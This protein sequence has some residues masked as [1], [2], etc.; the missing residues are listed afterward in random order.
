MK[1]P[2]VIIHAIKD[3]Y[4]FEPRTKAAGQWFQSHVRPDAAR[5]GDSLV[6]MQQEAW[7][8]IWCMKEAGLFLFEPGAECV[9]EV[10]GYADGQHDI[11]CGLEAMEKGIPPKETDADFLRACGIKPEEAD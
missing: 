6:V 3:R 11:K 10:C 9:C 5:V 4:V 7:N 8:V 1:E 2:D